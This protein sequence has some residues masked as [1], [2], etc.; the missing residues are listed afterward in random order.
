MKKYKSLNTGKGA[1]KTARETI[2]LLFK[3]GDK[4]L[5]VLDKLMFKFKSKDPVLYS[6]YENAR[7]IYDKA[8]AH[9]LTNETSSAASAQATT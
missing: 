5:K 6:K 1:K 9:R 7:I 2:T 3:K 4:K 8:G